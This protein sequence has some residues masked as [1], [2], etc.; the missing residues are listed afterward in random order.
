MNTNGFISGLEAYIQNHSGHIAK[1]PPPANPVPGRWRKIYWIGV[2]SKTSGLHTKK[3][4]LA[5]IQRENPE[6]IY[7]R[8]RGDRFIPQGKIKRNDIDGWLAF[9]NA[10]YLP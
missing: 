6:H 7:W 4:F 2:G 8:L 5:I 10:V 9:A 1:P 3:E